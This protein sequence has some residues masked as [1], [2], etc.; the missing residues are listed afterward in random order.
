MTV[1]LWIF[2]ILLIAEFVMAPV[3]LW[4]GRTMPFFLALTGHTAKTA[5]TVFAPVKLLGAV[6][7]AVG[8]AVRPAGVAGAAILTAVCLYYLVRIAAPGRRSGQGTLAFV[9]FGS[10][11]VVVL[12]LQLVR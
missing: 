4:T 5:R 9:L 12:V 1:A 6:L 10:W 2:S 11:A 3:N 8:L 7:V